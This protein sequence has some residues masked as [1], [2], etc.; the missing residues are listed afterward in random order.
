MKL[1]DEVLLGRF[2]LCLN[3]K[4]IHKSVD[5]Y[6]KLGLLEVEGNIDEGW[7][8]LANGNLRLALYQGHIKEVTLNFRG[9]NVMEISKKL[10]DQGFEF[11][12]EPVQ[13]K[14]GSASATLK[15]PDGYVIFFDTHHTEKDI[16]KNL[17]VEY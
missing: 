15:D 1:K 4:D 12:K 6:K 10:K 17:K 14:E 3:I 13:N 11:H 7:M 5:F 9:G 16:L 8:V 2:D